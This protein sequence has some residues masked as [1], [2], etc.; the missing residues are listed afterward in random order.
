M[1]IKYSNMT[2]YVD[3]I[4]KHHR[5][6]EQNIQTSKMLQIKYVYITITTSSAHQMELINIK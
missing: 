2:G 4:F 1:W 6:C 5:W 3:K